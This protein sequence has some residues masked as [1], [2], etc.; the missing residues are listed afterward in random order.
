M[1]IHKPIASVAQPSQQAAPAQMPQSPQISGLAQMLPV[2]SNENMVS[3]EPITAQPNLGNQFTYAVVQ[4]LTGELFSKALKSDLSYLS[5]LKIYETQVQQLKNDILNKYNT[6]DNYRKNGSLQVLAAMQNLQKQEYLQSDESLYQQ[7]L[8]AFDSPT[9]QLNWLSHAIELHRKQL[10]KEQKNLIVN[11]SYYIKF[12]KMY[13]LINLMEL[14]E[15]TWNL[16][17]IKEKATDVSLST[18]QEYWDV[19]AQ[20]VLCQLYKQSLRLNLFY[21]NKDAPGGVVHQP[22]KHEFTFIFNNLPPTLTT[23]VKMIQLHD[24]TSSIREFGRDWLDGER[25][26]WM[27]PHVSL[28][29]E[30]DND[31]NNNDGKDDGSGDGNDNDNSGSSGSSSS[32]SGASGASSASGASGA[33]GASSS[34]NA[35]GGANGDNGESKSNASNQGSGSGASG[36]SGANGANGANTVQC[37]WFDEII[38]W[39]FGKLNDHWQSLEELLINFEEREKKRPRYN[40][41]VNRKKFTHK[42]LLQYFKSEAE[43]ILHNENYTFNDTLPVFDDIKHIKQL[44]NSLPYGFNMTANYRNQLNEKADN[45]WSIIVCKGDIYDGMWFGWYPCDDFYSVLNET[46]TNPLAKGDTITGTHYGEEI[47][48]MI[49]RLMVLKQCVLERKLKDT[50]IPEWNECHHFWGREINALELFDNLINACKQNEQLCKKVLLQCAK[51]YKIFA[52]FNDLARQLYSAECTLDTYDGNLY[53]Y[54]KIR[55]IVESTSCYEKM[56]NYHKYLLSGNSF[57]KPRILFEEIYDSITN[58]SKS[59]KSGFDLATSNVD[60]GNLHSKF[61]QSIIYN[62]N[63]GN[64]KISKCAQMTYDKLDKPTQDLWKYSGAFIRESWHPEIPFD[65]IESVRQWREFIPALHKFNDDSSSDSSSSDDENDYIDTLEYINISCM[66]HLFVQVLMPSLDNGFPDLPTTFM[67]IF[68]FFKVLAMDESKW[69]LES[70]SN[71]LREAE[72]SKYLYYLWKCDVTARAHAVSL[73]NDLL[74]QN[75]C[76]ALPNF[77]DKDKFPIHLRGAAAKH[78]MSINSDI[79]EEYM[80]KADTTSVYSDVDDTPHEWQLND[81]KQFNFTNTLGASGETDIL[82][83]FTNVKEWNDET[84]YDES[85]FELITKPN[86]TCILDYGT[87]ENGDAQTHF[88]VPGNI[89]FNAKVP[90]APAMQV[91]RVRK[92]NHHK[93]L[94]VLDVKMIDSSNYSNG[95]IKTVSSHDVQLCQSFC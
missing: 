78:F 76:Q 95:L 9:N 7:I 12:H 17:L 88:V 61:W 86:A 4:Q 39:L 93:N 30:S 25:R 5:S 53:L 40:E 56:Q 37:Q 14:M 91:H 82:K 35:G 58:V 55:D 89:V 26:K 64:C 28:S 60:C 50:P 84:K 71:L 44:R 70:L 80:K 15:K 32:S 94:F 45:F 34:S 49:V 16:K 11:F 68:Q 33:S 59:Y 79:S 8:R 19:V 27:P 77:G 22:T 10:Q 1:S 42:I 57:L 13:E 90:S 52:W 87:N 36:A 67:A 73:G 65:V 3:E 62:P 6:L 29:H 92:H 43:K 47:S 69:K 23:V 21:H 63:L 85:E 74:M 48:A 38:Q 51:A 46:A 2:L 24:Q 18:V 75:N 41:N 31:D 66:C 81:L 72:S 83:L 20:N 54:D